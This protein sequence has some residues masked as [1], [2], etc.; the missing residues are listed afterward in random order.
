MDPQEFPD[1]MI[2]RLE[3]QVDALRDHVAGLEQDLADTV[4]ENG[5]LKAERA[6]W[7][8]TIADLTIERDALRGGTA[9]TLDEM[10]AELDEPVQRSAPIPSATNE[11]RRRGEELDHIFWQGQQWAVTEYGI[12]ARDAFAFMAERKPASEIR[13]QAIEECIA[14]IPFSGMIKHDCAKAL[15]ALLQQPA[16]GEERKP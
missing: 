1:E 5:R 2:K 11:V 12:E 14:A 8:N 3:A 15:R 6:T 4:T 9:E 16:P 10:R 13:R 7:E